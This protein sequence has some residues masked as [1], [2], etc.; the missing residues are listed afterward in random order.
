MSDSE[1]KR[2]PG[3][4]TGPKTPEGKAASSQ[5]ALR[6]GGRSRQRFIEGETEEQFQV[7]RQHW[8]E[9]FGPEGYQEERLVE[10]LVWNDWFLQRAER[11][12]QETE[13]AAFG[14]DGWTA[15][16]LHQ[17]QLMQRYKTTAERSF[18]RAWSALRGLEKDIHRERIEEIRRN[19]KIKCLEIK[20][21]YLRKQIADR[22]Q[23]D[24]Q[25][26]A[27]AGQSAAHGSSD[28]SSQKDKHVWL[29]LQRAAFDRSPPET[30]AEARGFLA[31]Q[32]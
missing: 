24:S 27:K 12:L 32:V 26:R 9:Q 8:I 21:E 28:S 16:L 10:I 5:N 19:A 3:K 29:A 6:H 17:V 20:N 14:A 11:N 31:R 1:S 18:Y 15:E 2:R 7:V 4:S 23:A 22:K 25:T 30:H 13:A